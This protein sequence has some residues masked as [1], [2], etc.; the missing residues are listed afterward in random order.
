M[1]VAP[2][3][4]C[5]FAAAASRAWGVAGRLVSCLS[6]KRHTAQVAGALRELTAIVGAHI[7]MRPLYSRMAS[8]FVWGVFC[9]VQGSHRSEEN[10]PV[11]DVTAL[12]SPECSAPRLRDDDVGR[13]AAQLGSKSES[14]GVV[15]RAVRDDSLSRLFV[16]SGD[17]ETSIRHPSAHH[18]DTEQAQAISTLSL[19]VHGS[20]AVRESFSRISHNSSRETWKQPILCR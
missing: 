4:F 12:R 20:A 5:T 10:K 15:S 1:N 16:L 14:L 8:S 19:Y 6:G 18:L 11:G 17:D 7:V 9:A 13:N 3:S 2:V